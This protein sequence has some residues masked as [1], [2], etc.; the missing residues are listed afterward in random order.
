MATSKFHKSFG[1]KLV[2]HQSGQ[3]MLEFAIVATLGLTLMFA[4]VDFGRALNYT[5]VMIG[6]SRQGSNLASRGDTLSAAAQAVISGEAP[7]DLNHNGEVIVTAVTNAAAG[8]IVTGQVVQG[9]G[10]QPSKIGQTVGGVATVPAAASAMLQPGQTIFVTE[11]FYA[12]QPIT[13]IG[14]LLNTVMPST[15]Y[16]AAYF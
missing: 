1:R 9:N 4:L 11:V 15:L 6:L 10:A 8:Y 14:N 7:L 16:E 13:P 2:T 5:Q 12:F 3:A